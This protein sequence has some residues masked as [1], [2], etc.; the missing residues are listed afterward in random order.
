MRCEVG[1]L[2]GWIGGTCDA[3]RMSGDRGTP[4]SLL[5]DVG[6]LMSQE[7]RSARRVR[8]VLT[9]AEHHVGT[10]GVS[11][12]ADRR[13]RRGR[14]RVGMHPHAGKVMPEAVLHANADIVRKRLAPLTE[15]LQDAM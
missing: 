14:L 7:A 10:G 2:L 4:A 3:Q 1:L 6:E 12:R 11:V 8:L 9:C 13:R 15:R 5:D